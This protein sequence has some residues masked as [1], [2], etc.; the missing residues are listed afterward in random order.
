MD[1][2]ALVLTL[3]LFVFTVGM[4]M[5]VKATFNSVTVVSYNELTKTQ[6]G[7]VLCALDT[8]NETTSSSS[9]EHCSLR[10]AKDATCTGFNIK[11]QLTCGA[12]MCTI[13]NRSSPHVSTCTFYQVSTIS[14][15]LSLIFDM[16]VNHICGML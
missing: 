4:L 5:P 15:V 13:L 10:C 8:A 11:N 12:V 9:L 3:L 2:V 1:I 6:N 14:N 16:L 7:E